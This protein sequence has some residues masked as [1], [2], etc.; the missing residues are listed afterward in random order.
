MYNN[1]HREQKLSSKTGMAL[2]GRPLFF[3]KMRTGNG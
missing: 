1:I 2:R 3:S